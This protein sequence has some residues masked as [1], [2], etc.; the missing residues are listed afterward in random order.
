MRL[1]Y[2]PVRIRLAA[3][4]ILACLP[5]RRMRLPKNRR[6]EGDRERV[7]LGSTSQQRLPEAVGGPARVGD[8]RQAPSDRDGRHGL[9]DHGLGA[10]DGHHAGD[11][12]PAG[13]ALRPRGRRLRRPVGPSPHDDRLRHRARRARPGR[14]VRGHR[15]RVSR[16]PARVRRRDGGPVLPTRETDVHRRT[17]AGA[18]PARRQ[19]AR[20]GEYVDRRTRRAGA[21]RRAGGG[22]RV[23]A[24]V[25]ARLRDVRVLRRRDRTHPVPA[26]ARGS[27][28]RT[29]RDR[30]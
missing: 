23:P 19:L 22:A 18:H 3:F 24:F 5:K 29:A 6:L 10:P 20:S 21:R 13:P 12:R 2:G 17:D 9:R 27:H 28:R 16:V 14:T 25:L 15:Q 1:R 8:R 7:R 4:D 26:R 11:D 30:A